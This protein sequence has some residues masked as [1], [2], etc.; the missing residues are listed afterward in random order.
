MEQRQWL[1][2]LSSSMQ[3]STIIADIG[4]PMAVSNVGD[5][6]ACPW[7]TKQ[8]VVHINSNSSILRSNTERKVCFFRS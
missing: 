1:F 8:V 6:L 4:L 3:N 2:L 5:Q 7:K